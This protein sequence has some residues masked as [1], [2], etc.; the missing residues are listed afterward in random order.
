MKWEYK[1]VKINSLKGLGN[2]DELQKELNDYGA[3]GW[4]LVS[5]LTKPNEGVGW[6]PKEDEG[7]VIF[8]RSISK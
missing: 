5:S 2:S 8:K 4:E 7:S 6:I 3:E 1:V